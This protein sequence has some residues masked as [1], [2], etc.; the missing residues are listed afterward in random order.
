MKPVGIVTRVVNDEVINAYQ[1]AIQ[2]P[3]LVLQ[4]NTKGVIETDLTVTVSFGANYKGYFPNLTNLNISLPPTEQLQN[5]LSIAYVVELEQFLQVQYNPTTSVYEWVEVDYVDMF[6]TQKQY[7]LSSIY[8]QPGYSS[9]QGIAPIS[10]SNTQVIMNILNDL[11][12]L[13]NS[14]EEGLSSHITEFK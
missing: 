11:E 1:Y 10:V 8:I 6:L 7:S 12:V 2:V 13:Y 14:L 3:K 9:P 4:N 5:D